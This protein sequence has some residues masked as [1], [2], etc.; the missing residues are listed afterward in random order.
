[1]RR[2]ALLTLSLL[3]A[4]CSSGDPRDYAMFKS[5]P[6]E[7]EGRAVTRTLVVTGSGEVLGIV[8]TGF[9]GVAVRAGSI[10]HGEW[11]DF[12]RVLGEVMHLRKKPAVPG[13][14]TFQ[15]YARLRGKEVLLARSPGEGI[16]SEVERVRETFRGIDERLAPAEDPVA[17]LTGFLLSP[18]AAV[19]GQAVHALLTIWEAP[20]LGT[21]ERDRIRNVLKR[22][23]D[24][25][26]DPKI[27]GRLRAAISR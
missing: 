14:P 1:M 25:E 26:E 10:G 23:L 18:V 12:R 11:V 20:D 6:V 21:A 9:R 24:R 3:L 22:H 16:E 19:R 27:A 2:T 13:K 4:A 8:R 5:A 17:A 7:V 15:I